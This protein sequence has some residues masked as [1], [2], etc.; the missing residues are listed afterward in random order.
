MEEIE[1]G[2]YVRTNKGKMGRLVE[3]RLGF[4]KDLQ[5]YQNIYKLNNGLWTIWDYIVKH[6]EQLID[7]IEIEDLVNG[8]RVT[9][10]YLFAGEKTVLETEGNDKNCKCLC[11]KDIKIVLTKEQYEANCY[12]AGGEDDN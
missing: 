9:D 8:Y 3:T 1:I 12:K 7:L 2:E 10:K 4:N 5:V 11:E 6:S